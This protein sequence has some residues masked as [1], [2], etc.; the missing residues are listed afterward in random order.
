M[1]E[2]T[3]LPALIAEVRRWDVKATP[4]PWIRGIGSEY[5]LVR[6]GLG[7]TVAADCGA[8][9]GSLIAAYRNAA[10]LLADECSRLQERVRVLEGALR[11]IADRKLPLS[12]GKAHEAVCDMRD[13]ARAALEGIEVE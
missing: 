1:T 11:D 6:S 2:K 12:G 9:N 10:P 5:R 13:A 4:G 8:D 7:P 3:D